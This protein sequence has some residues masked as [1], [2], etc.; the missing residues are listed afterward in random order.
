MLV[1]DAPGSYGSGSGVNLDIVDRIGEAPGTSPVNVGN[2][3][4][5]NMI[6]DDR[7]AYV[8]GY[9]PAQINNIAS[10]SFDGINDYFD[11]GA[12]NF[13]TVFSAS[14]W[15][16]TT[17]TGKVILG[18]DTANNYL[19]YIESTSK[20]WVNFGSGNYHIFTISPTLNFNTFY[21][22]I[23]VRNGANGE[24]FLNGNSQGTSTNL[25]SNDFT[26]QYIGKESTLYFS[27]NIDEVAIFN[28]ALTPKQ[29]KEDIYNASTTGKTADLNNNSNLTAPVAW[30]RMGD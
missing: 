14:L 2:S 9:V 4:S 26:F 29:I 18:N 22:L 7:H 25:G 21:S 30:Y 27:G 1:A 16:K 19:F 28:Y 11:A 15:F 12:T 8:P 10:M 6:P 20:I 5:Y 13:G 17:N 23:F 24:L 3:Q